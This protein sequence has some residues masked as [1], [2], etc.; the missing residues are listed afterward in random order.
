MTKPFRRK[1]WV[2]LAWLRDGETE[3]YLYKT[4]VEWLTISDWEDYADIRQVEVRELQLRKQK[5]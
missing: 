1:Y 2:N 4:R 3:Q 5:K